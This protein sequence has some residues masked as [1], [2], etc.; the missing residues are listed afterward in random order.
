LTATPLTPES[1]P[2]MIETPPVRF[3]SPTVP[4][5]PGQLVCIHGWV[6]VPKPITGSVDGLMIYDNFGGEALA[7][8]IG[9][10]AGWRP[11]ILYRIAIQPGGVN[12]TFA[13]TG[14][15]EA[16]IDDVGI[17]VLE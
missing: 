15:G 1:P 2:A 16:Q 3:V 14:L 13:L 7:D 5:Q 12:V 8:R 4:A 17:E 9:Q 11:F 6:K 10:T